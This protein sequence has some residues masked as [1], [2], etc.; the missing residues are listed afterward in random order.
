MSGA[1]ALTQGDEGMGGDQRHLAG[2]GAPSPL[3]TASHAF[4]TTS[5][6]WGWI[7]T[8]CPGEQGRWF[9]VERAGLLSFRRDDYLRGSEGPLKQ[10]VWDK[11][12]NWGRCRA[13]GRVL[14]LGNVRCLGSTSARSISTS[15]TGRE[16]RYLLAEVSNTPW[17]ERHY[18]LLD[19]AALSP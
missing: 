9:A 10:A 8:N 13:R 6:C 11:V 15:A 5:S 1:A 19:L 14:L 4:P 12:A 2:L 17:N 16:A 7:W 18:Y 3:R